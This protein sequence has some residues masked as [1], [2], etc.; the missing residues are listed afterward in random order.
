MEKGNNLSLKKILTGLVKQ[1][2]FEGE[3]VPLKPKGPKKSI[4]SVKKVAQKK[5]KREPKKKVNKLFEKLRK[6]PKPLAISPTAREQ[7]VIKKG[8][9]EYKKNL[10]RN[11]PIEYILKNLN[12]RKTLTFDRKKKLLNRIK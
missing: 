8:I 5:A 2:G 7:R 11:R 1:K 6:N 10:L 4:V 12:S 9:F 3:G